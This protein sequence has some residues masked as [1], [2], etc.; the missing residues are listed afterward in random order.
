M[1]EQNCR[2]TLKS[3]KLVALYEYSSWSPKKGKI[4]FGLW[5]AAVK[6]MGG[7]VPL[8]EFANYGTEPEV[9]R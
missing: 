1:S 4:P 8:V 3:A 6:R 2:L 5:T 9:E 7:A